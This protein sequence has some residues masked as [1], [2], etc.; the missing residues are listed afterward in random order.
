MVYSGNFKEAGITIQSGPVMLV[1]VGRLAN[2]EAGR[3]G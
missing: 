1:R 2:D 3:V